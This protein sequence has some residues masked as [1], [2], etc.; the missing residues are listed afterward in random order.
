MRDFYAIRIKI[1]HIRSVAFVRWVAAA[2]RPPAIA[3]VRATA[4]R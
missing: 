2:A 3:E 4:Q 1:T